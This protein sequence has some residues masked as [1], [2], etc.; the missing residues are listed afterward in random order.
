MTPWRLTN[1]VPE[2]AQ[3]ESTT[4]FRLLF[5]LKYESILVFP[6]DDTNVFVLNSVC[7][8]SIVIFPFSKERSHLF[9]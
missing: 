8:P 2:F 7:V 6:A 5:T 1:K 4:I 3:S 9:K